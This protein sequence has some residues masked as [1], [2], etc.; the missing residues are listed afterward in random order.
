M[1]PMSLQP[2]GLTPNDA[3]IKGLRRQRSLLEFR[4]LRQELGRALRLHLPAGAAPGDV[5]AAE[6][7]VHDALDGA[8]AVALS[9]LTRQL[10]EF[11]AAIAHDLRQPIATM[12]GQ[13]QLAV[14]Q[15]LRSQPDIARAVALLQGRTVKRIA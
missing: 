8:I 5:S 2:R 4:L 12:T 9:A 11:L 3:L 10:K 15:L 7:V 6:L 14:R 1:T 13:Q